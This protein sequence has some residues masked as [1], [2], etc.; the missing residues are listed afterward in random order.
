MGIET[1]LGIGSAIAGVAGTAMNMFGGGDAP[2]IGFAAPGN[3][4]DTPITTSSS[5]YDAWGNPVNVAS[6]SYD[7][8]TKSFS[9][10]EG[11]LSPQE[12]AQRQKEGALRDQLLTSLS[13]ASSEAEKDKV[14]QDYFDAYSQSLHRDVDYQQ[15]QAYKKINEDMAARGM[16]GSRAY[17]DTL[18]SLAREKS[19]ADTDIANKSQLGKMQL[20]SDDY[21]RWLATL[22][23][24]YGQQNTY[25]QQTLAK[26]GLASNNQGMANQMTLGTYNAQNAANQNYASLLNNQ[27]AVNSASNASTSKSLTDTAVGL[28]YLYGYGKKGNLGTTTIPGSE[29]W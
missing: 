2:D 6:S 25:V 26:L 10:S 20:Y 27:Y 13:R 19:L 3:V 9:S 14:Y 24:E 8:K 21:N 17:V 28:G 22:G 12:I 16:T 15:E 11:A 23:R 18:D 4:S 7:P 29:G 1:A 5:G